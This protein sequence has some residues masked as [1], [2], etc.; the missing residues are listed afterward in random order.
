[1]N[2]ILISPGFP[3][4][5]PFFTTALARVGAQVYG[6]G[7]Q[8]VQALDEGVRRAL[9]GYLQV[10]NLW[11]EETTTDE[12]HAWVRGKSIDRV[13]CLWEPGVVLAGRVREALDVPGLTVEQSI[14]LRDKVAMKNVIEAAGLRTPKHRRA[15]T[16]KECRAAAEEIGYPLIIKPIAGAGS[17]DTYELRSAKDLEDAL[18]ILQHVPEVSIEEFIEGEEHTFDTVCA[19]GEI[20]FENVGWYRPKPLVARLNEW[21][22]PQT[23]CLKDIDAPELL[24]GRKLGRDVI[25]ALGFRDGFTHMEWFRTPKGEAVFGEIGGRPPGGQM[26]H[27]MNYATDADLFVGWAEALVHGRIR[28][29]LRKKYNVCLVFKRAQGGGNRVVR[30]EGLDRV[31]NEIGPNLAHM[32]LTPLGAPKK[33][34]RQVVQGDGW[35]VV[36]HPELRRMLELSDRV[37]SDLTL[38]AG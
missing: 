37:A 33:D 28:Q 15:K 31:L 16:A 5:I 26:V 6:V 27:G 19:N 32:E 7:D 35:I 23:V 2:V 1:M 36:R 12:I 22:S 21:I 10:K 11:D 14:P 4:Q 8:P 20:L 30:Y 29:D 9:A 3:H 13:E 18:K 24:P 38:V 17:A 34:W 25:Q